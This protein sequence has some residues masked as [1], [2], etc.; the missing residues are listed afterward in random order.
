[1]KIAFITRST[2]HTTPGGDTV[3]VLATAKYLRKAGLQV[4]VKR[5]TD[6]I[7][8][9][10]YDLLHFFNI[11]R[12]ADIL[13]HT[14]L[15]NTPYVVSPIFVDYA[16]YEKKE[17][18]GMAG[19]L[20]RKLPGNSI[21]YVKTVARALSGKDSIA[22][23]EYLWMG[24]SASIRRILRQA[25]CLLPNSE[26]EYLRLKQAYGIDKNYEVIPNGIDPVVF[27]GSSPVQKD[28]EMVICAARIEGIKNQLNL[29]RA[30]NHTRFRLYLLGKP[31][32]GHQAYYRQCRRE[33]GNNIFFAGHLRQEE[34]L[35]YYRRAKVHVLPSWFETTGLSSL[36]AASQGCNIVLTSKGDA[37]EYA[38]Q[39]GFYCDPSSPASLYGAIE[40][41][42]RTAADP[43]LQQ[44]IYKK[45]TWEQAALCTLQ[46]YRSVL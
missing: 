38:G 18:G 4:D 29:V 34:L 24:Q 3:Q 1:L 40:K 30:L 41:A 19:A 7:A 35:D 43:Q 14:R 5:S 2:L 13:R 8:Y 11:I 22:S 32:P 12:P 44:Q 46:A 39:W 28:P 37:A 31:A 26:N 23:P 33:A 36:E 16:E 42:S 27:P 10:H 20:F 17:R 45:F 6:K 21:E 25:A 15:A 9:H